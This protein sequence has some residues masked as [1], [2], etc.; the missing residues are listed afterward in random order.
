MQTRKLIGGLTF[1]LLAAGW[2]AA[3]WQARANGTR[4]I[5]AAKR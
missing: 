4:T 2:Q 5:R 3:P 1:A